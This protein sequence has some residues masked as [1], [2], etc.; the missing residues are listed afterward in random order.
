MILDKRTRMPDGNSVS[1]NIRRTHKSI[2]V[3]RSLV[4]EQD[5]VVVVVACVWTLDLFLFL[6]LVAAHI[7]SLRDLIIKIDWRDMKPVECRFS[8]LTD[9]EL[10]GWLDRRVGVMVVVMLA[11]WIGFDWTIMSF[12]VSITTG[13]FEEHMLLFRSILESIA[14]IAK[15]PFA[16]FSSS[17]SASAADGLDLVDWLFEGC[18]LDRLEWLSIWLSRKAWIE[19]WL[20]WLT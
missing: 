5:D 16:A 17:V 3:V 6:E 10:C 14:T 18:V 1:K 2:L 11:T 7:V 19:A 20:L 13:V 8:G 15:P 9:S 12:A 4:E